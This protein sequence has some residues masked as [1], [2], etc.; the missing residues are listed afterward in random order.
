MRYCGAHE[1]QNFPLSRVIRNVPSLRSVSRAF[2][3]MAGL[4][5]VTCPRTYVNVRL[6]REYR[7]TN[8]RE[9]PQSARCR[10]RLDRDRFFFL[11]SESDA[12]EDSRMIFTLSL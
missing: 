4:K 1:D 2:D 5:F 8:H 9:N 10:L 12:F 6:Y 3:S 7:S 11:F